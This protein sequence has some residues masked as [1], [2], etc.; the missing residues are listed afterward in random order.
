MRLDA[1]FDELR[2][3]LRGSRRRRRRSS[4]TFDLPPKLPVIQGDRDKVMLA[5]HNLIG[6]ALKYTPDGGRVTVNVEAG[7]A[8]S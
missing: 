7:R 5:L 2:G 8:S 6:N 1:L 3:R 4:S